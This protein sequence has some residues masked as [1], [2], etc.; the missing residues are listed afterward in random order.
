DG[1]GSVG[2]SLVLTGSNVGS[3][4][5]TLGVGGAMGN[6]IVLNQSGNTVTGSYGGTT[7][8]TISINQT[9]GVVTFAQ[10]NNIWHGSTA[11]DDDS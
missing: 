6:E 7:Y 8:F 4:L 5:Y 9:T 1:A 10:S 3:G 11:S 2:Y